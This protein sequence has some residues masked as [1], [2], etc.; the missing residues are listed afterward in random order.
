MNAKQALETSLQMQDCSHHLER[1]KIL[2]AVRD[3]SFNG[4]QEYQHECQLPH[5]EERF[6][7]LAKTL[8]MT[9]GF[10]VTTYGL[11]KSDGTFAR[12]VNLGWS[13]ED[14]ELA[15]NH[16]KQVLSSEQ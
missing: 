13:K 10:L 1:T 12:Y 2:E 6:A 4:L 7:A 5:T 3:R 8:L 15:E 9:D 11:L 16:R 14:L